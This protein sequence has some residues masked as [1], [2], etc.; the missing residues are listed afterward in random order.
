MKKL[1]YER[2]STLRVKYY[3]IQFHQLVLMSKE[4]HPKL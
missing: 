3:A 4:Q 2:E 1:S